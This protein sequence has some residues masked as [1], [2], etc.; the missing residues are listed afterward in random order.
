MFQLLKLNKPLRI[1][2]FLAA[3]FVILIFRADLF[4]QQL[5]NVI[6]G[7][8]PGLTAARFVL[9][10]SSS[11]TLSAVRPLFSFLLN[12]SFLK[13]DDVESGFDE[14][15]YTQNYDNKITVK[16][17][18]SMQT[19]KGW[20]SEIIFENTSH[21]TITISNVV[22]F[23]TDDASVYITGKGPWDLARAYLFRPGFRPVRVVLPDNAW[24]L[25]YVSF[26]AGDDISVCALARRQQ[27]ESGQKKR[28]E[29]TLPP[30]A[31]VTYHL[32]ADVFTGEWQ[33]GLRMMF[34]DRYLYD[35]E[36]FDNK[37]FE[38]KDLKWIKESYIIILQMAWDREF[39]DRLT[40]KYTYADELRRWN[41]IFGNIDVFG[42]WPTW[43]R[44]GLDRRNQWDMYRDLPGGTEI[45]RNFARLSRQVNTKFFIAYNPWDNST[46]QEDHYKGMAKLISETEADG[47]VLD[48][49]GSSSYELQA[50]ADSVRKGVVMYSEGMAIT[51][52]MPGIIAGRVHNA[53]YYSPEI[54]LN[55]II[56]P[57][58]SIF[59]VCDVGEDKNHR[60]IAIAFFNGYGT[61]LNLFRPGGRDDAYR[62]DLNYLAK[63]T[64]ILR[65]NNDA[66]LDYN[67]TPMI[68][69]TQ[70]NVFV[71]KWK[72]GDKTVYTVLNMKPEGIHGKLFKIEK[73][74]GKH[75][76]S[77]WNHENLIPFDENGSSYITVNAD[78]WA[79]S[80]SGTRLEGSVECI[81]QVPDLIKAEV[82]G[83]S[84]TV[85]KPGSGI[86]ILWKGNPSYQ[87]P[88]YELKFN[89]DTTI[90]IRNI[91]G[92]YE[93]K[94]VMQYLENNRLKDENIQYLQGGKPWIISKVVRTKKIQTV[95]PDMVLVPKTTITYSLTTNE[96]F[97]PYPEI[98]KPIIS[99]VDSFLIDKYPVTNVQFYDFIMASGYRPADTTNYLK[100]WQSG[101]YKQGQEKY[102]V[103]YVSYEDISAYAKW[104]EKRLPTQAEWQLASQGTDGR[105]WPW[106]NEFHG[107]WCNNA[108][109]RPTP[110]DAFSKGGSPY[111]V[112]DLVGNVWQMTN[113]MYFNGINYF[114]IIRGG[115]YYR[116]DSS[117]WYIQGGPHSLDRTQIMLMV[118]PGFD[119]CATVGF[120]CVKDIDPK[121]FKIKK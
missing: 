73:S 20:K 64:F 108:F 17:K 11:I 13:S 90:R 52:D 55:K 114:I 92:Y 28:Y 37:L 96:D 1:S 34:R 14:T 86:F 81:V 21:D 41:E 105:K 3:V 33:N 24:E 43:P 75:F 58:F 117:W 29:T 57:D 61:E 40:G 63:T 80:F 6:I 98:N 53:I 45:L 69:T 5:Q 38:R 50:A 82:K 60:E 35:L 89:N 120:R 7:T 30:G 56:K 109:D 121:S 10:D 32:F 31:K 22:P 15:G 68:A 72:S 103:V 74:E 4:S 16:T 2:T 118:S 78:G 36:K 101:M 83:D 47:V 54:N 99:K 18:A 95:P 85:H 93:G 111:G 62:D 110:V 76:V 8:R 44:L 100:H 91:I 112:M 97:M 77:L 51:K 9:T 27:T 79:P 104:A 67:W 66:F 88:R 102:P 84:L 48:T 94:M 42:I 119:R 71:N 46:R 59:R 19:S 115:S 12:G 65:Q 49:R 113:D 107:T 23:S 116:P 87:T 25:G 106:G 26:N 39:Y 70:D